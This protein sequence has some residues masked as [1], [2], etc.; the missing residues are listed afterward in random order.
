VV[1]VGGFHVVGEYEQYVRSRTCHSGEAPLG[2]AGRH[3]QTSE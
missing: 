2:L 3:A 1:Q